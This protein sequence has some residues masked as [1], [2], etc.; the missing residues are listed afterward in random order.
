MQNRVHHRSSARR[1]LS[2]GLASGRLVACATEPSDDAAPDDTAPDTELSDTSGNDVLDSDISENAGATDTTRTTPSD[3]TAGDA[4]TRGGVPLDEFDLDG[5]DVAVTAPDGS[6]AVSG[7]VPLAAAVDETIPVTAVKWFV[8]GDEVAYAEPGATP[9]WSDEWN[10]LTTPDGDYTVFAKARR[11]DGTWVTSST[12]AVTVE[13][14]SRSTDATASGEAPPTNDVP[15]WRQ[16]FVDDFATDVPLGQFPDLV[17]DKWSA[18]PTPWLDT[19]DNGHY[20]PQAV[21]SIDDGVLTKY[22]H[23]G[24]DGN[25]RV[26]A[27]LPRVPGTDEH[28]TIYGRYSIRFRSESIPGYKIAWLLWPDEG[29]NVTGSVTGV[30]GNGELNWPEMDLDSDTVSG[31]VHFQDA[32]V[33]NDQYATSTPIDIDEWHTYTMEWSPD[34]VVMYLDGVEIGRTTERIPNTAMH[35]VIQTETSLKVEPDDDVSGRLEI[36]WVAAWAYEPDES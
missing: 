11:T 1:V 4:D 30:G 28:G 16:T 23:T 8:D 5:Q 33:N 15:G 24:D 9:G 2:L 36:D 34:L 35:W 26:A 12:V 22:L 7:T 19:S 14:S 21:V 18:Y 6:V 17:G 20:D 31:F 13:N 10:T 27:L 3:V 25:H 32:I 29:T